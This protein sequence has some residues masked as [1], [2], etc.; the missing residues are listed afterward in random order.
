[1]EYFLSSKYGT[2]W[3]NWN[4]PPLVA[5]VCNMGQC[6]KALSCILFP[7]TLSGPD[8]RMSNQAEK[9]S[10]LEIRWCY[11]KVYILQVC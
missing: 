7:Q 6:R 10:C 8:C 1:M 3:R 5:V 9:M 2:D 11:I 4:V